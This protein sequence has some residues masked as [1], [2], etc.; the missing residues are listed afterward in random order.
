MHLTSQQLIGR[1]NQ[2]TQ[3]ILILIEFEFELRYV[4]YEYYNALLNAR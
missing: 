3:K 2:S 1:L 4:Y